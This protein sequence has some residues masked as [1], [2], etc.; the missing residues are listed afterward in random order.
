MNEAS[1]ELPGAEIVDRTTHVV[2]TKH[3]DHD[4]VT[5][6]VCRAAFPPGKS[7]RQLARGRVM[8]E[9]ARLEGYAVLEERDALWAELPAVE[10][11]SRWRYQGRTIYQQQAHLGLLDTWIF[12]AMSAPMESRGPC[13]AWFEQVRGSLQ[14]RSDL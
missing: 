12:F 9:M 6:V 8:D 2:E 10:M 14:L 7:V 11:T 4:D 13:D 1:F 5:L 3:P